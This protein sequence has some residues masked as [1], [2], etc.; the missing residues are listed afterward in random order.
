MK[1]VHT[2]FDYLNASPSDDMQVARVSS[3]WNQWL[4]GKYVGGRPPKLSCLLE[5]VTPEEYHKILRFIHFSFHLQRSLKKGPPEQIYLVLMATILMRLNQFI[6]YVWGHPDDEFG[7]TTERAYAKHPFL[8]KLSECAAAAGISDPIEKFSTWGKKIYE[9]FVDRNYES[10][11]LEELL[12]TLPEGRS[13][14]F[15]GRNLASTLKSQS[16]S[17]VQ[18]NRKIETMASNEGIRNQDS[19]VLA[20]RLDR[21]QECVDLNTKML[22]RI[23]KVLG[24]KKVPSVTNRDPHTVPHSGGKYSCIR[25]ECFT[26]KNQY[27]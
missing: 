5:I 17:L 2:I 15:D 21:L 16:H 24:E 12:K 27:S 18:M 19:R 26:C 7:Q 13:A 22:Q 10:V 23:C 3:G 4:D 1:A 14:V 8:K 25:V 20:K 11:A 6:P 9:S